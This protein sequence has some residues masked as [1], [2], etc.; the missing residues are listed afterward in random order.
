M[1]TNPLLLTI[2]VITRFSACSDIHG[3]NI[4]VSTHSTFMR[5]FHRNKNKPKLTYPHFPKKWFYFL[6]GVS[7]YKLCKNKIYPLFPII[8]Q[9]GVL[10]FKIIVLHYLIINTVKLK[11]NYCYQKFRKYNFLNWLTNNRSF[12]VQ[13]RVNILPTYSTIKREYYMANYSFYIH[14]F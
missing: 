12:I 1:K 3:V 7:L 8:S 11:P 5:N 13:I 6:S 14:H 10:Y 2:S 9:F 4:T